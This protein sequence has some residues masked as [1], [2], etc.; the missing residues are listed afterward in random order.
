MNALRICLFLVL[1]EEARNSQCLKNL[2]YSDFVENIIS[3]SV[4][5]CLLL[6]FVTS[7]KNEAVN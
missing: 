3:S 7:G 5:D 4:K 6:Y 1:T 2:H